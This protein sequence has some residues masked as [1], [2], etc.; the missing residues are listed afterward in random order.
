MGNKRLLAGEVAAI[1]GDFEAE[2][3][4]VD[5]FGGMCNVAGSLAASK[6]VVHVNDVQSYAELAA[7]CLIASP[8]RP[9]EGCQVAGALRSAFTSNYQMLEDRFERELRQE[10]EILDSASRNQMMKASD[11]W[12]HGANDLDVAREIARLHGKKQSPYRLCTL[13]FAWSYFG[14]KQSVELDSLRFAIDQAS[15]GEARPADV[16]WLRLAMLQT[17]SRVASTPGHFAQFLRP[18]TTAACARIL[19]YRRRSVWDWFL[20]DVSALRPYGT[21]KWRRR[22]RVTRGD[23]LSFVEGASQRKGESPAIFYADPPYSKEHYSRFYHVL[24]T[25]ERYDYPAAIGAGRYRPD[26]FQSDF[27]VASRVCE[28]SQRLFSGIAAVGG[29]LLFSYPSSGLLSKAGASAQTLLDEHF[30]TVSLVIDRPA[31]HSTLG[32]RHGTPYRAVREQVWLAQ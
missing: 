9:P 16:L 12:R 31:R 8:S 3:P 26:R 18:T 14:L 29:I 22:N 15:E 28:A 1:C 10:Q 25:L 23:A 21:V 4:L 11:E 6:R 13:S 27:A 2:R 32:G 7:R 19:S 30:K 24:E 5:L 17:A 20:A